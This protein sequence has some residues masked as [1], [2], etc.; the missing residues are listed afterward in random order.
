MELGR[1]KNSK[2]AGKHEES[3]K[4]GMRVVHV[5]GLF[6]DKGSRTSHIGSQI[7]PSALIAYGIYY[8]IHLCD[9]LLF[10]PFGGEDTL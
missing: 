10:I 5:E 3:K 4:A 2:M 7:W 1:L 9:F 8:H 6:Q